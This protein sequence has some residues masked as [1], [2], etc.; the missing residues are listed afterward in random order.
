M[1]K[2]VSVAAL[3][4]IAACGG[5]DPVDPPV[6][7]SVIVTAAPTQIAVNETAQA[8][9]VVKDQNGNTLT[10]KTVTWTSTNPAVAAVTTAGVI[11]GVSAG[12]ATIQGSVDGKTGEAQVR[13]VTP[14]VS[15]VGTPTTVTLAIGEVRVL[16]SAATS[17]CV[18]VASTGALSSQYIVIAANSN[19]TPDVVATYALKSDTG[20]VV[21]S[22]TLLSNPYRV[23]ASLAVQND[24]MAGSLQIA[25]E[26]NLRRAERRQLKIPTAQRSLAERNASR[27]G[28][29]SMSVAVPAVGEKVQFKVPAKFD[30]GGNS[31]GGSCV[32]F[33]SVTATARFISSRSIIFTDD[34]SPAGGFADTDFQEIGT[35]FDNLIY[36]TNV[37]Y[38]GTPLDLD[39][40]SRVIILYT[41]LVNRL[42]PAGNPGGF[43]G[44]FFFAGDLF[45]VT[46]C[47]Q[48]NVAE[49]FY[50][51]TP[52]PGGTV[53][54]NA[55][56]TAAVRQGTRGT[57]AHEFQHMINAS[58]R[59]RSP[60]EQELEDVW[61]DEGL[62]HFAEDL[63]GRAVN[64]LSETGNY[65]FEQLFT[66][67]NNYNAFFFQ[68]FARF[69]RYLRDPGPFS[70]TSSLADTSLAVR[71]AAWAL[72]RYSADHYA[73]GG[74]IKAF[75]RALAGGPNTGVNNLVTRSGN[76]PFDTL[77][78]GWMVAN[79]AD[80]AGI[81]GLPVKYTYKTYNIRSNVARLND[82]SRTYPLPVTDIAGTGF[83][84]SGLQA[85]SGSG[86][87]FFFSQVAG[88]PARSFRF[89]NDDLATA[90]SFTGAALYILRTN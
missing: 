13:V 74:D 26:T 67:T 12:T 30:A 17:G 79:Y 9:A 38:F 61:L 88:G 51:L 33:T 90:A 52:D 65:T 82:P 45:P 21:P 22:T 55:R 78:A 80:D 60:I 2:Q 75:T 70:P 44:G 36:P 28:R 18:K 7:T 14:V 6:T 46:G 42:T 16:S 81:S 31:Q 59:I 29:M 24:D 83:L 43:V 73:P 49:V 71:G 19:P 89:L 86:N 41:P 23:A 3:L 53:N 20:E 32:N 63:N 40:N 77:I 66:N 54:G 72:V 56:T 35:E 1:R 10:G 76:I 25:F 64:G 47:A 4:L 58:E 39:A 57:I 87:Y 68:N 11:R 85:R 69:M 62:S 48:S 8:S 5:T 34:A 37:D 15:C 27:Q 84:R 50:L